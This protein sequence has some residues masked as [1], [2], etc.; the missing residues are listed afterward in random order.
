MI[1]KAYLTV[2]AL[3]Y[4]GLSLWCSF[5]PTVTSQ[6]VG[7][8][9]NGGSGQSEFLTVY[10]GLEFSLTLILLLGVFK[11]DALQFSLI[12]CVLIHASLVLFR[13]IGFFCFTGIEPMTY[14]LA[15]GEW[16]IF[17]IGL[18]VLYSNKADQ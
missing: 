15:I 4:L 13:S 17:L 5:S 18:V 10:G 2:V 6:K 9:L 12:S 16:V 1:A 14:K 3:L 8:E 7:F 11:P